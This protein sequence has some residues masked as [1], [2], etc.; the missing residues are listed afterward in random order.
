[1]EDKKMLLNSLTKYE[2]TILVVVK[3]NLQAERKGRII[4]KK[5]CELLTRASPNGIF[6]L[7]NG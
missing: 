7:P 2:K 4:V 1:M 5:V 3:L 6:K